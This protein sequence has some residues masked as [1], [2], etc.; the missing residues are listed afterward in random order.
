M[1][2]RNRN[3]WKYERPQITIVILNKK[4]NT[5]G[6]TITGL[7][8]ILQSHSNKNRMVLLQKTDTKINGME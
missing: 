7:Q 5:G 2:H 8:I 4:C 6:I 3:I 1:L